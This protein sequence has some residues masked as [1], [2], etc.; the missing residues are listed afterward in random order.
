MCTLLRAIAGNDDVKT[1]IV[2]SGG[3]ELI[4]AAMTTHAK[5]S[6]VAEQGCAALGSISLRNPSNCMAIVKAGGVD[7]VLKAM[8]IH[9]DSAGVQ[10]RMILKCVINLQLSICK[11]RQH[12]Q[13]AEV[14]DLHSTLTLSLALKCFSDQCTMSSWILTGLFLVQ[15][16]S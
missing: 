14:W 2:D 3:L 5:H 4:I 11:W 10:V 12:C 13:G 9:K 8:Q 1:S 15:F 7:A 16:P 6:M